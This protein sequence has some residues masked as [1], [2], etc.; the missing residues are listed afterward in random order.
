MKISNTFMH[1]PQ[2]AVLLVI[3]VIYS[4]DS[5]SQNRYDTWVPTAP[6]TRSA[7]D[8]QNEAIYNYYREKNLEN[9]YNKYAKLAYRDLSNNDYYGFLR[10]IGYALKTGYYNPQDYY[11]R[12]YCFE[13]IGDKISAKREYK[14]A[15]K[16]GYYEAKIQLDR[17]KN[18]KHG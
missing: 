18:R 9:Q 4:H 14:R 11:Y 5:F 2:T 17:M 13:M 12:G 10:Y 8:L 6:V 16:K 7:S 1:W 15:Y 3:L